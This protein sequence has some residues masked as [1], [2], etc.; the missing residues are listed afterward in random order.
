M[1]R[2]GRLIRSDHLGKLTGDGRDAM[3]AYGVATVIDLR[4]PDELVHTPNPFAAAAAAGMRYLHLPLI[5]DQN[6]RKLGE[7]DD[8]L[9]R[10]LTIVEKR[11]AAFRDVFAAI[12]ESDGGVL[13][14]CFAG[15][16]RTGLVAAMLLEMAGV[17]REHIADDYGATDLQLADQYALWI[18]E[19]EPDRRAAFREELHCPPERILGVLDHLD[20]RWGG[21]EGYLE[22]A[23]THSRDLE[24]LQT[25]LR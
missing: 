16:D 3:L 2:S 5:D 20:R 1:T 19:A 12:A 13:F 23:G 4:S 22:A 24:R 11:P 15:K 21:V 9:D 17:G 7:S 25:L 18:A 6:M 14:H 10:Y 8:M